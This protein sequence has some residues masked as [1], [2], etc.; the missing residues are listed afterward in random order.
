M[1]DPGIKRSRQHAGYP[2]LRNRTA[3][4]DDAVEDEAGVVRRAGRMRSNHMEPGQPTPRKA[5][6]VVG[7]PQATRLL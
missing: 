3:A 2:I 4:P 6:Q 7:S 1:R 5:S